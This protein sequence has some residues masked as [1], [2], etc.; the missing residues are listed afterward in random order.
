[1]KPPARPGSRAARFPIG[2]GTGHCRIMAAASAR[3]PQRMKAAGRPDNPVPQEGIPRLNMSIRGLA[4]QGSAAE[5][6][7][8]Q[9]FEG[10]ASCIPFSE[11]AYENAVSHVA[12][13][14]HGAV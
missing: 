11:V 12:S 13:L 2:I 1:M 5:A 4:H 7:P 10:P 8:L 3:T 6:H 14:L 9:F